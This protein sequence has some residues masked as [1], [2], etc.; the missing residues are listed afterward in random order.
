MRGFPQP[1]LIQMENNLGERRGKKNVPKH[2]CVYGIMYWSFVREVSVKA[3]ITKSNS[4]L[5]F[6]NENFRGAVFS[7]L[8]YIM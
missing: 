2:L 6:Y 7:P 5:M 4:A 3:A 8:E 1:S